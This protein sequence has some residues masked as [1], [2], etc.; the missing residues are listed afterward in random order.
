MLWLAGLTGPDRRPCLAF[1]ESAVPMGSESAKVRVLIPTTTGV[2]EILLLAEE[3]PVIGRSVACIGG[4]TQVADIDAG[5]HAF[6]ARPTG[7]VERLFGHSCYRLDVSGRIDAGSSW[8]LGV[9]LAHALHA[10]GRLAQEGDAA[11]CV[12][13]ATGTVRSVDLSVGAVSHVGEKV[14]LSL[15]RLQEEAGAGRR[16]VVAVPAHN[17]AGLSRQMRDRL[18]TLDME[19]VEVDTLGPLWKRL[20]LSLR[21]IEGQDVPGARAAADA[22]RGW[23]RAGGAWR[24]RLPWAAGAVLLALLLAGGGLQAWLALDELQLAYYRTL[25]WRWGLPEGLG[26]VD[27]G[28]R[29]RRLGSYRIA[30]RRGRVVEVRWENSAGTLR[31]D[32]DG[33]ARWVVHYRENG[34]AE[35]VEV[36]RR[37]GRLVREER[38]EWS[39]NTLIVHFA[40]GSVP[41]AQAAMQ[42]LMADPFAKR[43][44][45][46][47]KSDITR[48]EVTFDSDGFVSARRYQNAWGTPVKDGQGSF[49]QRLTST[50]AGRVQRRAEIGPDGAEIVLRNGIRAVVTGYDRHDRLVR[51]TLIGA[52]GRPF[53]GPE[54]YAYYTVE[55]DPWGNTTTT[56]YFGSDGNP[57][58][59]KQGFAAVIQGYDRRGNAV[60]EAYL[61]VDG[62]PTLHENG[63]AKVT[64]AYTAR[65]SVEDEAYLGTDGG[66]TLHKNGFARMSRSY[67]RHGNLAE[68]AYFGIDGRP[69]L[70]KEGYARVTFRHDPAGNMIEE[71]YHDAEGMATVDRDGVARIANAY[72]AR[73]R[74]IEQR[75]FGI[76]GKL[77]LDK[78]HRAGLA[79]VY[80]ERG[81]L[82]EVTQFG[83]DAAPM[84]GR[85]GYWKETRRYDAR[86]NLTEIAF[87]GADGR[88]ARHREGVARFTRIYDAR[89]N[90]VEGA[91]FDIDGKP[92]LHADGVAR[93]TQVY[94]ARGNLMEHAF[95]GIDGNPT[96]DKLGAAKVAYTYDVRNNLIAAASFGIDGKPAHGKGG[97]ARSE[98]TYDARGNRTSSA[99]FDA[100][101]GPTLDRTSGVS[102]STQVYDARGQLREITLFGTDGRPLAEGVAKAAWSYDARGRVTQ[103]A[104][105]GG[106]G[107]S[108]LHPDGMARAVFTYNARGEA[109]EERYFGV[110]GAPVLN[111]DGFAK[112]TQTYDARGN[113]IERRYFGVDGKATL[114]LPD[115]LAAKIR[116]VR[117]P[118]G[119]L[120]TVEYFGVDD[121]AVAIEAVVD[122]AA[123]GSLAH[124]I[125]L[126]AGDRLV[127][128]RGEKITSGEHFVYVREIRSMGDAVITVLR[129]TETLDLVA[130]AN[131]PLGLQL[132]NVAAQA[133]SAER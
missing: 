23:R 63:Y 110:D 126:R 122:E 34:K 99:V 29:A 36:Y 20:D 124:A 40:Y 61:G 13:W 75:Y 98:W 27:A 95:F 65:G 106:D 53:D 89:G 44:S 16:V 18:A 66:P 92:V 113:V 6:V 104:F 64:R 39:A 121:V 38:L 69:T 71:G 10:E 88:P 59:R 81:N 86:G 43:G 107:A 58:L 56:R 24:R 1:V 17:A 8:Q 93:V 115:R 4:T 70:D 111:Q 132:R 127:S 46:E 123:P 116:F 125:G 84:L 67:D 19:V 119:R 49:G 31:D 94:D 87:F 41:H 30:T 21:P 85:D 48:H 120:I 74:M 76:D 103:Q 90:L 33:H 133:R 32:E 14:A 130:P 7:V 129:G 42:M 12:I 57:A 37:N 82:T 60:E 100:Q 52:D 5:Y 91:Y 131:Q 55:H 109:S 96:L 47:G 112:V 26:R 9:L 62:R 105:F 102:K 28:T 80:D 35:K 72:D 79:W 128:W 15:D 83:I 25:V 114:R 3:D 73:G 51:R 50:L 101:G 117:D 22:A 97:V 118:R 45:A 54:W 2:V 68:V 108:T 77:T 11:Q 78:N